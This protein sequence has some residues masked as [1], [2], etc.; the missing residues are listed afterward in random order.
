MVNSLHCEALSQNRYSYNNLTSL[1]YIDNIKY[2]NEFYRPFHG[3]VSFLL[4]SFGLLTNCLNF[5]VL[6]RRNMKTS[7]N[8]VLAA[9]AVCDMGKMASYIIFVSHFYILNNLKSCLIEVYT[10]NWMNFLLF[11]SVWSVLLHSSSLWMSVLLAFMRLAVLKR[12]K[13][14]YNILQP[15]NTWKYI[16]LICIPVSACCLPMVFTQNVAAVNLPPCQSN[17]T[18][19]TITQQAYIITHS[20][21]AL[22]EDCLLLR[23]TLWTNGITFKLIPC[24]LL[25]VS[26]FG[27]YRTLNK[28]KLRKSRLLFKSIS[29]TS[30][31]PNEDHL[32]SKTTNMLVAILSVFVITELPQA[33]MAT[34]SGIFIDDIYFTLYPLIGDL[35]DMLSLINSDVNFVLYCSMSS[36][37][38][39]TFSSLF[40]P[41]TVH[42]HSNF[43]RSDNELA[44][45]RES[46]SPS[47]AGKAI[48][49]Q[50]CSNESNFTVYNLND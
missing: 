15:A 22:K 45:L 7:T 41:K 40:L 30:S 29:N 19:D 33:V 12:L 1:L 3:Y 16:A 20:S 10:F 44:F 27:L 36:R 13:V 48:L 23:I 4:C 8:L 49:V 26:I 34:L 32:S 6:T 39:S 14:S 46:T 50:K 43:S 47:G 28:A 31:K 21:V 25:T 42:H 37:F 24:F 2:F 17:Y 9:I 38:R 5:V 11:H 35:L 18:N